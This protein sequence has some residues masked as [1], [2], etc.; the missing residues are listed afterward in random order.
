MPYGD[1][2]VSQP[3]SNISVLFRNENY[4][5]DQ[6][7]PIINV[8]KDTDVYYVYSNDFKLPDTLRGNGSPA[9]RVTWG[10][11]TSSFAANEHALKDVITDRDRRNFDSVLSADEDTTLFLTDKILL[12]KENEAAKILFTTTSWGNS[13]THTAT[14]QSWNTTTVYPI[15]EI[16]S[17]AAVVQKASGKQANTMVLGYAPYI[18]LRE[19]SNVY[20]RI[21][22]VER[23][24]ITEDILAA[25]F[26]IDKVV[27]GRTLIDGN[28]EGLSAATAFLWG[29]DA[30]V[31]FVAPT[32]GRKIPS[33]GYQFV[34]QPLQVKKWRDEEVSGDW[35][36][37]G[38]QYKIATVA[39]Q[40][41]IIIK[42]AGSL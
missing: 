27:V 41:G 20:A 14:A 39:S 23:A 42:S 36:Q 31:G 6:C 12:D 16:L 25:L 28:Y 33:A 30:W 11:S 18:A 34:S 4:I 17:A 7:F 1:I 38:T 19:N 5:A 9:N 8:P 35:I 13:F 21:Q 10:V 40:S 24:I 3:L 32:P 37:V 26:D 15:Q 22:Y 29:N 2:H